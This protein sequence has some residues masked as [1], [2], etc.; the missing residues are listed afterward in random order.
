MMIPVCLPLL[1]DH[2]LVGL[3][4]CQKVFAGAQHSDH[5]QLL[6]ET[7]AQ[8]LIETAER[9]PAAD[10]APVNQDIQ[11]AVFRGLPAGIG[12]KEAHAPHAIGRGDGRRQ[13]AG[14]VQSCKS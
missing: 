9:E 10:A 3:D 6:F 1:I 4:T 8:V 12:A 14:F 11:I 2:Y 5:V 7:V 13:S